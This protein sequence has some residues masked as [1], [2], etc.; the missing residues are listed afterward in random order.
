MSTIKDAVI[1]D[2]VFVPPTIN[3]QLQAA[4]NQAI[5]PLVGEIAALREENAA[6]VDRLATL[7]GLSAPPVETAA[8]EVQTSQQV[9]SAP[10]T[11]IL[12]EIIQ[13]RAD[14]EATNDRQ[15]HAISLQA[16]KL[17]ELE[18]QSPTTGPAPGCPQPKQ[19]RDREILLL[20][21]SSTSNGKMLQS[22][23]RERMGISKSAF[24]RLLR[25]LEGRV[26]KEPYHRD[27]RQNVLI[28]INKKS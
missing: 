7:E 27:R 24:S 4:I 13:L 9:S 22:K 20:I 14:M 16:E 28:L 11:A 25:T 6:L 5:A 21:L 1:E 19:L 17:Y 3:P 15:D 12:E 26:K 2:I 8:G 10:D 23:A 18:A